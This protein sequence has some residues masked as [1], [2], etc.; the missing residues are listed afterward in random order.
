MADWTRPGRRRQVR[1]DTTYQNCPRPTPE[2]RLLFLLVGLKP[3]PTHLWHGRLFGMRPSKATP[4]IHVL[5][6]V[7]CDAL[8]T[9]GDAPCRPVEAGRQQLGVAGPPRPVDAPP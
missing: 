2:D 3:H 7:W 6:P 4:W 9:L 8:R 1:R 5:L